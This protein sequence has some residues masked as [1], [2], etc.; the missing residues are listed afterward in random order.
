MDYMAELYTLGPK[1]FFKTLMRAEE[2]K[3]RD[4]RLNGKE[5]SMSSVK[6]PCF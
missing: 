3:P 2:I 5:G 4:K 1:V 6:E